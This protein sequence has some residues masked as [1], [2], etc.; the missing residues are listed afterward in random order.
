MGEEDEKALRAWKKWNMS[1]TELD[2]GILCLTN[3]P[4]LA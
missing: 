3:K 2:G 4:S 1:G